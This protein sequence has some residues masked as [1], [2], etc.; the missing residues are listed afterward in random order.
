MSFETSMKRLRKAIESRQ[1][2]EA[3][4]KCRV[5]KADLQALLDNHDQ[6]EAMV[7]AAIKSIGGKC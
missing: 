7:K 6:L 4:D 2:G 3:M 1:D 5:L